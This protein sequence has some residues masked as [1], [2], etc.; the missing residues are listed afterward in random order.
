VLQAGKLPIGEVISVFLLFTQEDNLPVL[1]ALSA[2]VCSLLGRHS[3]HGK[4][5]ALRRSI[6][7]AF[8]AQYK[9][10]GWGDVDLAT[11]KPSDSVERSKRVAV[12]AMM[13][14]A[15]DPLACTEGLALYNAVIA[16]NADVV[17]GGKGKTDLS[18]VAPDLQV[19]AYHHDNE[20]IIRIYFVYAR[21]L[22]RQHLGICRDGSLWYSL[23]FRFTPH[24]AWCSPWAPHTR[25][26][27]WTFPRRCR[28]TSRP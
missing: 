7:E 17:N 27:S 28:T 6:R 5:A 4:I 21:V 23:A 14:A 13:V 26:A 1:T 25:A 20:D 16:A 3:S 8:A 11:G 15:R 24:R 2:N 9:R 19:R 10:F 22:L 12:L 18:M